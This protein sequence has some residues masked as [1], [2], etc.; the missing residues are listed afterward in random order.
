[1]KKICEKFI[2]KG[3][4]KEIQMD[5]DQIAKVLRKSRRSI[6]SAK[7]LL[8]NSDEDSAFQLA[9]GAMLF[10]GR[11]LFFFYGL[12]PRAAGSHKVVVDF[13]AEIMGPDFKILAEI[14]DKMRRKRNYL[15]YGA[16]LEI[17]RKEAKNG[18][19]NAEEFI[20]KIEEII[21]AKNPQKKLL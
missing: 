11:A 5:F 18:I 1:M 19:K 17:S 12:R 21:Q 8:Q 15:I 9:Y 20:A 3:L 16:G 6:K 10:A 2:K 4:A 13:A 7:I 14:F